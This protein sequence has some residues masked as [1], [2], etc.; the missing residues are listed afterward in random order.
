MSS[1][2]PVWTRSPVLFGTS[3]F[4]NRDWVGNFYPEGTRP[5]DYLRR[6]AEKLGAVEIDA[7]YYVDLEL[8]YQVNDN[9]RFALGGV[10]VFDEYVDEIGPPNANRV[11]VGLPYPRRS[12]ANYEG[13]SWYLKGVYSF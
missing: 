6:Y 9:L 3:S 8:G 1:S 2:S 5:A 12:A 11:S 7:T 13:G 10:N 4:S